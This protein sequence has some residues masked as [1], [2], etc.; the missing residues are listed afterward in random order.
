M[1]FFGF[2]IATVL[3][4]IFLDKIGMKTAVFIAFAAH[5]IGLILTVF[6]GGYQALLISTLFIGFANGAV[7]A[8]LNPLVAT[9][10]PKDTTKMLN[11]FHVWFPAGIVIGA[12]LSWFLGEKM[13][14]GWRVQCSIILIPAIMYGIF[15]FGQQFPKTDRVASGVSTSDMFKSVLLNPLFYFLAACMMLTANTELST[16]QWITNLL[17]NVGI[18]GLLVLALINGVMAAGRYFAGPVV[19]KFSEEGVLLG[20][21]IFAAI[22]LYLLSTATSSATI[23][24]AALVFAVGVCY[25]WPTMLG[26]VAKTI[27]KGGALGLS[28]LGAAGML[29]TAIFQPIIGGWFDTNKAKATEMLASSGLDATKFTEAVDFTAGKMTLQNV[30]ML[31]LALIVAFGALWFFKGKK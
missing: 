26:Y 5:L 18:H 13:G 4:G 8:A 6:A 25:F 28:L 7:E 21:S 24:V 19:H 20:S 23:I 12:V 16:G 17:K 11:R 30:A 10:Y 29:A 22:G 1:A 9:L 2:P 3:G 31:P 15:F 14:I 27:P